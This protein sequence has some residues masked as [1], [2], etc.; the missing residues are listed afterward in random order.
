MHFCCELSRLSTIASAP[1][2]V[3]SV[4]RKLTAVTFVA[5]VFEIVLDSTRAPTSPA[6]VLLEGEREAT[7]TARGRRL[8]HQPR[9][10]KRPLQRDTKARTA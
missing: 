6:R 9:T 8:A 3:S 7:G 5:V 10:R 4:F 1:S 2:P